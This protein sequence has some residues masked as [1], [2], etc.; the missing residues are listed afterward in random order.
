MP[1]VELA[2]L[3]HDIADWKLNDGDSAV[4]PSLAKGWLDSQELE[5]GVT[6]HVCQI[7]AEISFKGAGVEQSPLGLEG[8]IVQNA[9]CLDAMTGPNSTRTA[10]KNI[11]KKPIGVVKSG[12]M[13]DGTSRL[14]PI[15]AART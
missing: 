10:T 11:L 13:W 2:A 9:D 6:E 15:F 8:Q 7:I 4:G 12:G 14:S 1:V 5:P 3:L